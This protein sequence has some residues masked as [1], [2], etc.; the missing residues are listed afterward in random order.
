MLTQKQL[1][2]L[3]EFKEALNQVLDKHSK[4]DI[5]VNLSI[6]KLSKELKISRQTIYKYLDW[7]KEVEASKNKN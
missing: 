5:L 3:E 6:T 1:L 7:L 2:L 4:L